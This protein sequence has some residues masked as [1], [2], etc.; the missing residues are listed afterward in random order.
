[1]AGIGLMNRRRA[2]ASSPTQFTSSMNDNLIGKYEM[3]GKSNDDADRKY[4]R[5]LSGRGNDIYIGELNFNDTY[6]F[7][8]DRL[9]SNV[10][11]DINLSEPIG[12][13]FTIIIDRDIYDSVADFSALVGATAIEDST[14]CLFYAEYYESKKFHTW[15]RG[16]NLYIGRI[17]GVFFLTPN[18]YNGYVNEIIPTENYTSQLLTIGRVRRTA[19]KTQT[20]SIKSIY[21]FNKTFSPED[22]EQYIRENINAEYELPII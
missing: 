7:H 11:F 6:G 1:M 9:I 5:D 8:N 18:C 2:I 15:Y 17:N 10:V 20:T 3:R 19:G 13:E 14:K 12:D 16:S 4:I 21:I 22:I